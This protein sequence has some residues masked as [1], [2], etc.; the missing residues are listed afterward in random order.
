LHIITHH[1][2]KSRQELKQEQNLEEGSDA[3]AIE[4]CE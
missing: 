2:R 3:E 1:G 4:K